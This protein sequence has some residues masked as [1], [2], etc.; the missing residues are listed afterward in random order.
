MS[1]YKTLITNIGLS[2]LADATATG[3]NLTLTKLAVGDGGGDAVTPDADM[4]S[5]VNEVWRGPINSISTDQAN[6]S[7]LNIECIIP[8][9]VGGWW[10]REVAIFD[11]QGDLIIIANYPDTHKTLIEDGAAA[12]FRMMVI[13]EFTNADAVTLQIDPA[14]VMASKQYVDDQMEEHRQDKNPHPNFT[15]GAPVGSIIFHCASNPPADYLVCDGSYL[16]SETYPELYGVIGNNFGSSGQSF[17]LPDLRG[18]FIRGWDNGRGVDRGRSFG[19][20]QLDAFQDHQVLSE[21]S[22]HYGGR[23]TAVL[24]SLNSGNQKFGREY[25]QIAE[26][27]GYGTP[28]TANETRSRNLAL[29]ACIKYQ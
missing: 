16:D 7:H 10:M 3:N 9:S 18:E 12:E 8:T 2:K 28:R 17:R 6:P 26:K 11:D 1:N 21:N 5:L 13:A 14:I 23:G 4:S 27:S 25:S 15:S 24:T 19:S 20:N 29:L 22:L